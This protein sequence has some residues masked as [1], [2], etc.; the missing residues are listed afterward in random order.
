MTQT[1]R[2]MIRVWDPFVRFFHWSL[3]TA[4]AIAWLSEEGEGLHQWAGY[5]ALGLVAARLVWGFIGTRYAR[6]TDFVRAPQVGLHHVIDEARGSARRYIGHN[7]AGGLMILVLIALIAATGA[8]GWLSTTDR[9]FGNDLI[10]GLHEVLANGLLVCIGLHLAGVLV[11]SLRH[12]EN[13][14]RAMVTGR[15]RA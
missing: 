14:V 8:T 3:V 9:F 11:A 13:L 4:I 10:E 5:A 7:P 12:G 6:F 1:S 2:Q 15:K